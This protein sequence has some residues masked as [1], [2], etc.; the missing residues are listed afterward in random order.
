MFV[1]FSPQTGF[2]ALVRQGMWEGRE[3]EGE[4]ERKREG[5][6]G[7]G[8]DRRI[9][10]EGKEKR[11]EEREIEW[12][13]RNGQV[14]II[15]PNV[16]SSSLHSASFERVKTLHAEQDTYRGVTGEVTRWSHV[17]FT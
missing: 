5:G 16:V 3:E 6:G 7:E 13:E 17:R 1:L 2:Q 4:G 8:E 14:V 9:G 15:V 12:E 10:K 11:E